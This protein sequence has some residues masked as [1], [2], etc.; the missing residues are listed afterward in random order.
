VRRISSEPAF[1]P[2]FSLTE[3]DRSRLSYLTELELEDT[4]AQKLP[5]GIPLQVILDAPPAGE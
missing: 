2:Y 1:T 3:H 5:A 4:A